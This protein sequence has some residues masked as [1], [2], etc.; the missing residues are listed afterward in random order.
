MA[1]RFTVVALAAA[2]CAALAAPTSASAAFSHRDDWRHI[3]ATLAALERKAPTVPAVYLLG[4]SAA[5]ECL[6]TEPTWQ[7]L[8]SASG[9]GRVRAFN[10]GSASQSYSRDIEIVRAM[11]SVPS[12]VLIGVNVGRYTTRSPKVSDL[13]DGSDLTRGSPAAAKGV[14]DSHRFHD[15]CQ[16]TDA[17][18][19]GQA[20]SWLSVRYPVFAERYRGNAA[21]LRRLI[22]VCR[23][24]GFEPVLVELPLDLS[25]VGHAWDRARLRYRRDCRAAAHAAGIAYAAAPGAELVSDDFADVSHLVE[26]GR[27]KYQRRLARIAANALRRSGIEGWTP[28]SLPSL[29]ADLGLIGSAVRRAGAASR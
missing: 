11:P 21:M 14:Y 24:R 22:R 15:G 28:R 26:P 27:V 29:F 20:L 23:Q 19:R 9:G 6:T 5:R 13:G 10:F 16:L 1:W 7:A 12:V 2:V 17:A 8:I 25:V 3:T 18:K 4:G